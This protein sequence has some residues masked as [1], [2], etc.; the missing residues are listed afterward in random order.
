[1]SKITYDDKVDLHVDSSIADINKVSASDMNEIKSA[2]NDNDDNITA[3]DT[4]EKWV[5]V[6]KNAP[7]DGRRVWFKK[8]KNLFDNTILKTTQGAGDAITD[9]PIATGKRLT[10]NASTQATT[11]QFAVYAVMDLSNYVGKTIRFKTNYQ[12]SANNGGNFYIGLCNSDG[13]NRTV[14][15]GSSHASGTTASFEVPTLS[16]GQTYL[17]IA[18]YVNNGTTI[19]NK[20]DY[21]DYTD[22]ILT[23]DNEDMTYEPYVK[24]GIYIDDNLLYQQPT[25]LYQGSGAT[26]GTITLS[27]SV[28]NY[29]CVDVVFSIDGFSENVRNYIRMEKYNTTQ[30]FGNLISSQVDG[31]G[32][33][34]VWA[35][36]I[37]ISGTTATLDRDICLSLNTSGISSQTSR[38]K[39]VKVIGYK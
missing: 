26:T 15:G 31:G 12:I 28:S 33:L 22:M 38:I 16:G 30:I 39:V 18:L 37:T 5:A 3:L 21:V 9:T 34:R 11:A 35:T 10:Y 24:E 6:D 1:M 13:S 25:L 32:N 7:T 8:S 19:A 2:V 14:K 4:P 36:R 29:S 20:D 27:D 23:I 17:C